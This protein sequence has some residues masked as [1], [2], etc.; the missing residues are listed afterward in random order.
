MW[1]PVPEV[2]QA[3]SKVRCST[4]DNRSATHGLPFEGPSIELFSSVYPIEP[5]HPQH[6]A[7]GASHEPEEIDHNTYYTN[8]DFSSRIRSHVIKSDCLAG[9]R[10]SGDPPAHHDTKLA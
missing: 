8:N 5:L 7:T 2:A 6:P 4:P 3:R 9:A 1:N 10:R